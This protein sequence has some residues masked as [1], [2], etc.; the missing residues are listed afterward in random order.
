MPAFT[1]WRLINAV[2][3][4]LGS[5]NSAITNTYTCICIQIYTRVSIY[6]FRFIHKY[7]IVIFMYVLRIDNCDERAYY[8]DSDISG[9]KGAI[10]INEYSSS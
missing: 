8:K 10:F 5:Q 3:I 1:L 7:R 6:T 9:L 2:V 4:K